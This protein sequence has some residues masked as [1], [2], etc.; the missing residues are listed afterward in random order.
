MIEEDYVYYLKVDGELLY[1]HVFGSEEAAKSSLNSPSMKIMKS[2][3]GM[4]PNV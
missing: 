3:N 2:S 1:N 4:S